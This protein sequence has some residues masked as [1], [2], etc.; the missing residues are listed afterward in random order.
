MR[1]ISLGKYRAIQR[2]STVSDHFNILALDHHDALRRALNAAAPETVTDQEMVAFKAQ[3]V[4]ALAPEI[5]AVLLDPLYGAGQAISR[6]YLAQAGLL[7]ELER[8]G[9]AMQ[10]LPLLTEIL[11]NWNVGKI[12]RMGADGVK[13]FYYYNCDDAERAPQQDALLQRIAADCDTFDI[14]LYAE[15]ILYPLEQD[16]RQHREHFTQRVI[17]AAQRAEACGADVLKLEFPLHPAHWHDAAPMRAACDALTAVTNLPWVLLS[18]GVNF[19]RFCQQVEIACAAGASG[20]IAGRAVWGE[21]AQIADP[22]ACEAWLQTTGRERMHTLA[23]LVQAGRP[24]GTYLS[25]APV[26]TT[27]YQDYEGMPQ[28]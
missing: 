2:V 28:P 7:V 13:L 9:Y 10:P 5:S 15:P 12:K 1:Q 19:E 20:V 17:T 8:A 14:P 24:W 4:R 25:P 26:S 16:D 23:A 18:A 6:G 11:P 27:W 3:V 21:A 22:D